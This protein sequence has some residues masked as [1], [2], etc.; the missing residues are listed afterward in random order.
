MTIRSRN[1]GAVKALVVEWERKLAP[2]LRGVGDLHIGMTTIGPLAAILGLAALFSAAS[3]TAPLS[4]FASADDAPA[5]ELHRDHPL[6]GTF[7]S[8]HERRSLAS[9]EAFDLLAE[10]DLVILGET[11][12][13][14]DHHRFQADALAALAARG[15]HPSVVFE[16]IP[17]GLQPR[18]DAHLRAHPDDID[19]LGAAVD[20]EQRG[21]P[22]WRIYQPIAEVAA[23]HGLELRA[24]ALDDDVQRLLT[25]QGADALGED[26]RNRLGLMHELSPEAAASL[27]ETLYLAHCE[28]IPREALPAMR[29]IQW[30]RDGAMAHAVETAIERGPAVLIAGA[31]HA[32]HDWGVPAQLS[33]RG[34]GFDVASVAIMEV[35]PGDVDPAGYLPDD[36]GDRPAFDVLVFTPRTERDDP[37]AALEKRLER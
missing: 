4:S 12:D 28:L 11:H 6:V 19:G 3:A 25:R 16:M 21:W 33:A 32:R 17:Q 30:A 5:A 8:A 18:L 20:W 22:D 35:V 10:A 27:D 15:R 24:G 7:W 34:A 37:C 2:V 23:E 31:G 1:P 36:A 26:E 29:L 9:E 14:P 13:N